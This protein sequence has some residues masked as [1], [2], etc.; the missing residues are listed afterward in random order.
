VVV[1]RRPAVAT[2]ALDARRGMSAATSWEGSPHEDWE[3]QPTEAATM[4]H[5]IRQTWSALGQLTIVRST[6]LERIGAAHNF[7]MTLGC[8]W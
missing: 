3:E 7:V 5:V 6:D 1:A 4:Q 2:L 8:S